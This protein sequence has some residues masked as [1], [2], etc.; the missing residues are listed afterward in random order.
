MPDPGRDDPP[1]VGGNNAMARQKAEQK[2][3]RTGHGTET[4]SGEIGI[5]RKK[6]QTARATVPS[7]NA[8]DNSCNA[9]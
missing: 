2:L 8:E 6:A 4:I 5:Y 1:A 3:F 7:V 9:E